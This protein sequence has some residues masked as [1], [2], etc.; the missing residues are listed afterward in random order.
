[1]QISK[2]RLEILIGRKLPLRDQADH[3]V[4]QVLNDVAGLCT[5]EAIFLEKLD[6]IRD[7]MADGR[8][9]RKAG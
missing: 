7:L 4:L 3:D 8:I 2:E 9:A 1:M 5:S 6:R